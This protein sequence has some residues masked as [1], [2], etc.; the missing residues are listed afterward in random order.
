MVKSQHH[1]LSSLHLARP[2]SSTFT[3]SAPSP[4]S[5]TART[6]MIALLL[7]WGVFDAGPMRSKGRKNSR[8][9]GFGIQWL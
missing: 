1:F 3:L 2:S 6:C 9:T 5:K 4:V 8:V 7:L